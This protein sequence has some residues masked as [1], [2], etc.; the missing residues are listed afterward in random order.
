MSVLGVHGVLSGT[1]SA[2]FGGKK[3]AG[4]ATGII[5]GFVYAGVGA[6]SLLMGNLLPDK[7]AAAKVVENWRVWPIPMMV[8]AVIGLVLATRV[9]NA[10]PQPK[11]ASAPPPRPP[12]RGN[13]E[14]QPKLLDQALEVART[15][16]SK[17]IVALDLDS[18]VF[19]NHPRQ[20][21]IVAEWAKAKGGFPEV[22]K[23]EARHMDGWDLRRALVNVG[24]AP[25]RAA[26]VFPEVKAFW[27]ERFFTSRYCEI[28]AATPGAVDFLAALQET[29]VQIAYL[30]GRHEEMREGTL[31]CM[32]RHGMPLPDGKSVHLIMKPTIEED[33]DAFKK[34]SSEP[35]RALGRVVAAFDNEPVHVNLY[36]AAF[37]EA[38]VVHLDTD[39]SERPVRVL[40]SIPSVLDFRRA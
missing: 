35:L 40:E 38:H 28:D 11:T 29:G 2:D 8:V 14:A 22:E 33:D 36:K 27:R 32:K 21:A 15:A 12:R 5:D 3:N 20:A 13:R 17:G 23:I 7:P 18:T 1:A 6:Q 26:E 30:T 16:G 19:D 34:R 37:P 10:K 9:W 4:V 25:A 31:A 24:L 39:D